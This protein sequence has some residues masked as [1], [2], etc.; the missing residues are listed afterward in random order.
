MPD[1][2]LDE[3]ASAVLGTAPKPDTSEAPDQAQRDAAL[4]I[5]SSCIVEAP[6]GSGKTGLL[7]QRFLKLLAY[8]DIERPEEVLA[9]TFARDATAEIRNRIRDALAQAGASDSAPASDPFQ[10]QTL[11]LAAA[12]LARSEHLKWHLL[13]RPQSINVRSIDAVC[14]DIVGHLPV[15]SH[16][17][18]RLSPVEDATP[19]YQEAALRLLK[20]LEESTGKSEASGR[21]EADENPSAAVPSD[22]LSAALTTLLLHRDGNL[23]DCQALLAE[24]LAWR[25]QWGRLVP[26]GGDLTDEQLDRE[27]KPR[28]ER[29]LQQAVRKVL[30]QAHALF[31]PDDLRQLS[32]LTH[33]AAQALDAQQ[34]EGA[35]PSRIGAWLQRSHAPG[36]A[37]DDLEAWRA[38]AHQLLTSGNWRS[39]KGINKTLGY[40]ANNAAKDAKKTLLTRLASLPH[41]EPLRI[42][43]AEIASLPDSV[44]PEEQWVVAKALFRLLQWSV[45]ELK[46]L[47]AETGQCDFSEV[48]IAA[49]YAL[50]Q[51]SGPDD[52]AATMGMRLR[53]LL[54][55]E[56]QDTS[57]SQYGLL[58]ALTS[59]WD[60]HSQTVFLVGDPKQS[61][62]LFRQARVEL[63]EQTAT[64]GLG[65]I[66]LNRLRL[67]ANFRSQAALVHQFN[68]DFSRIFSP[69]YAAEAS[70]PYT[71]AHPV[72][73][74]KSTAL[75]WHVQA[76]T[77]KARSPEAA[78][79]RKRARLQEVDQIVHLL[80][81]HFERQQADLPAGAA[82][83]RIAVLVRARTH[84]HLLA[85]E[86]RRHGGIPFR[87]VE[88]EPLAEQQEVLDAL[89]LTRALLHPS[90]RAAWLSVLRAPW[91]GLTLAD[92]QLLTGSDDPHS[93]HTPMPQLIAQ[94]SA[95]LC[96]DSR[97]RLSRATR[98]LQSAESQR[99]RLPLAQ[100]VERVWNELGGPLCIGPQG[101]AANVRSYFRLLDQ[102]EEQA[103]EV[104]FATLSRR[105]EKLYAAP[106]AQHPNAVEL[107]TMHHAKGLEWDVVIVP[108][109]ER[110]PRNEQSRMLAW[111]ELPND[112]QPGE[113]LSMLVPVAAKGEQNTRLNDWVRGLHSKRITAEYKRL[114]YVA[115]TRARE[116]LHLFANASAHAAPDSHSLLATAW[117]VAEPH[118]APRFAEAQE[119]EQQAAKEREQQAAEQSNATAA[120][121]ASNLL[122]MPQTSDAT[123][124][125]EPGLLTSLAANEETATTG[126]AG[127]DAA[128]PDAAASSASLRRLPL[129]FKPA[130]LDP[131]AS[132]LPLLKSDR[133]SPAAPSD[134]A[135]SAATSR[136]EGSL[137]ARAVGNTVHAFL[138]RLSAHFAAGGTLAAA[139]EL[140]LQWKPRITAVLRAQGISPLQVEQS[141]ATAI[142]ALANTLDDPHGQWI[143]AAHSDASSEAALQGWYDIE[144]AGHQPGSTDDAANV[145]A[146][147]TGASAQSFNLRLDRIFR[148][149]A[150]PLSSAAATATATATA[151]ASQDYLWIVDYKTAA[152]SGAG[153]EDFLGRQKEIYRAKMESYAQA[154]RL[155]HGPHTPINLALYYPLLRNLVWWTFQGRV[156]P[157]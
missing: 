93:R 114:Y 105:M 52:L 54:V 78:E 156:D 62:Y 136:P 145:A 33:G 12:V 87:S 56:M 66:P 77:G 16:I 46:L 20:S 50:D 19:L 25:D 44:Y 130:Q 24:M 142:T 107:L 45:V 6:A 119:R 131:A 92:L 153:L 74:S 18:S 144:S 65:D 126:A 58:R 99:A 71:H 5:T 104:D 81:N 55:D 140:P 83:P 155:L 21:A 34:A 10:Q 57:V 4:D 27:V 113:S 133:T 8:A 129:D 28:L 9:I 98:T 86:L 112:E 128:G 43:L 97:Q 134:A 94:N 101:S 14:A 125:F 139:R 138:E 84:L 64:H 17:G 150:A 60:G 118:F 91:C 90:D 79:G 120:P 35:K 39:P 80:E 31:P 122:Q 109:L 143:L 146:N 148:A 123:A 85:A 41:S 47:F 11:D 115:C 3:A 51:H 61:I 141:A 82:P 132:L 23:A 32:Q 53:H 37:H 7:V 72:R 68:Q 106:Q 29:T 100:W 127:N 63:F 59:S 40:P 108:G 89:S 135:A 76:Y 13:D 22:S 42:A 69:S 103:L 116:E 111:I 38:L 124:A 48:S 151:T 157:G 49:Q 110:K 102:C 26:L 2:L 15:L 67:T 88:I 70:I 95:L 36:D 137:A 75:A 152:H 30:R 1:S 149:G 147:D 121:L 96:P 154:M 73:S 117:E